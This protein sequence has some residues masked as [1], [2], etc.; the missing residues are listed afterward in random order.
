M[1]KQAIGLRLPFELA[2][3]QWRSSF[4]ITAELP[5][6]TS[7]TRRFHIKSTGSQVWMWL[8]SHLETPVQFKVYVQNSSLGGEREPV[9]QINQWCTQP[10]QDLFPSSDN[11]MLEV[12]GNENECDA[13]SICLI[14]RPTTR[15]ACGHKSF[16]L[17]CVKA[18]VRKVCPLC[19][20]RFVKFQSSLEQDVIILPLAA[21]SLL[22]LSEL[23]TRFG[24]VDGFVLKLVFYSCTCKQDILNFFYYESL[25]SIYG[26]K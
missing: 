4:V 24:T 12:E 3:T 15:L 21:H 20:K 26:N 8:Y 25:S 19:R 17:S 14:C 23:I 5:S 10:L 6:G 7:I 22:W 18:L 9:E 1:Q 13:C 11:L 2:P 16:C